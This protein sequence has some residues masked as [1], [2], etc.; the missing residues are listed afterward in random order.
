M[1]LEY[2]IDGADV[3]RWASNASQIEC[4]LLSGAEYSDDDNVWTIHDAGSSGVSIF[5]EEDRQPIR[6]PFSF[7]SRGTFFLEEGAGTRLKELIAGS[8]SVGERKIA[9]ANV[10]LRGLGFPIDQL[11]G[12]TVTLFLS[13]VIRNSEERD[14][15][16]SDSQ[17]TRIHEILGNGSTTIMRVGVKFVAKW[18]DDSEAQSGGRADIYRR[19]LMAFLYRHT[20]QPDKALQASSVVELPRNRV[21]GD[22][23]NISVLCTTRAA[24]M[25]DMAELKPTQ[26]SRLLGDARLTLNKAYAMS[27]GDSPE[28]LAA[29]RRLKTLDQR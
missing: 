12:D 20:G 17:W 23:S 6:R 18:I 2:Q 26:K 1:K 4:E 3:A 14:V 9:D 11:G 15:I 16:P 24:A 27:G 21:I 7:F 22:N 19:V 5:S 10:H 8:M 28:I 25:M 13:D 29:Y